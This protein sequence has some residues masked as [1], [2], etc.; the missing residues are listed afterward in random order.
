MLF[1]YCGGGDGDGDNKVLFY[2]LLTKVV[3]CYV[4]IW[5]SCCLCCLVVMVLRMIRG[6][7][8]GC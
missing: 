1:F 4:D 7:I 6:L 3:F 8:K 5:L 2:R